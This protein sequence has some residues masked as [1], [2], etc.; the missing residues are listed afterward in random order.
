[1]PPGTRRSESHE[2][3]YV[4]FHCGVEA[5]FKVP[6]NHVGPTTIGQGFPSTHAAVGGKTKRGPM[7]F[8]HPSQASDLLLPFDTYSPTW[9]LGG[10]AN[11]KS[12]L[13]AD[14]WDVYLPAYPLDWS[15]NGVSYFGNVYNDVV[16]DAGNGARLKATLIEWWDHL[17]E[18]LEGIYGAGVPILLGGFSLGA[19]ATLTIAK[20]GNNPPVGYIAHCPATVWENIFAFAAPY[21]NLTGI[22]FSG[23]DLSATYLN[24]VSIPGIVGYSDNDATV[25]WTNTAADAHWQGVSIASVTLGGSTTVTASAFTKV[26]PGM[27]ATVASGSG[28]LQAG[29]TVVS[30]SGG[31]CVLSHAPLTTGTATLLFGGP[32]SNTSQ[33]I[34]AAIT[35]GKPVTGYQ[36]VT[37]TRNGSYNAGTMAYPNGHLI[38]PADGTQYASWVAST[39]DSLCPIAY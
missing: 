18:Y 9:D 36:A 17:R 6:V 27:T 23:M 21:T 22:N 29:T 38:L 20:S 24:T 37:D 8:L 30:V 1:M 5:P 35:A 2:D 25:G 33:M 32:L 4:T 19:W 15:V 3:Y 34:A 12:A 7:V 31:N 14:A 39:I 11:L 28:T 13:I 26:A 16:N 10:F